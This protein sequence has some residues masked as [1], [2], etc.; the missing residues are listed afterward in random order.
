MMSSAATQPT[1]TCSWMTS[2]G[3]LTA[4]KRFW[5][6]RVTTVFARQGSYAHDAKAIRHASR[7]RT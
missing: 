7:R 4:V 6:D 1:I 5:G 2:C 3:S